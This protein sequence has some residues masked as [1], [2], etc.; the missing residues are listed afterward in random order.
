VVDNGTIKVYDGNVWTNATLSNWTDASTPY[1]APYTAPN[2]MQYLFPITSSE[3][4]V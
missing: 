4:N 3:W 1:F 2:P